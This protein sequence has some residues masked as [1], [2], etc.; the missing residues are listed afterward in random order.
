MTDVKD[1]DDF[2]WEGVPYPDDKV[3]YAA[4]V[5]HLM[6]LPAAQKLSWSKYIDKYKLFCDYEGKR[7]RVTGASRMG[8]I[9]LADKFDSANGYSLRVMPH[10][11]SNWGDKS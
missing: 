9:M 10:S 11:C 4:W 3:A 7:Y 8:D 2:I 5:L 1:V 6:R